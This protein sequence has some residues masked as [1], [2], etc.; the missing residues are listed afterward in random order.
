MINSFLVF[1]FSTGA[2]SAFTGTP[3]AFGSSRTSTSLQSTIQEVFA[4]EIL[5]SRG[6]PT[7]EVN[8]HCF[9]LENAALDFSS[10]PSFF[11]F[12]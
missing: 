7:V 12:F 6:N 3:L 2:S 9:Y 5:D 10:Y 4:R 1:L 8:C 11:Y